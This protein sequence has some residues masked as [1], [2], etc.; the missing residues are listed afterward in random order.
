VGNTLLF[1]ALA[2]LALLIAL[3]KAIWARDSPRYARLYGPVTKILLLK[4][5]VSDIGLPGQLFPIF[6]AVMAPAMASATTLISAPA[7]PTDNLLGFCTLL[8]CGA[9]CV[10]LSYATTC[11]LSS[12]SV[13]VPLSDARISGK[14]CFTKPLTLLL[15]L[16]SSQS[17]W[18][19]M[20]P[21]KLS[22]VKPNAFSY[23]E[24]YG[25]LFEGYTTHAWFFVAELTSMLFLSILSGV[26]PTTAAGCSAVNWLV[27]TANVVLLLLAIALKPYNTVVDAHCFTYSCASAAVCGALILI[28]SEWALT[29][30]DVLAMMQIYVSLAVAVVNTLLKLAGIAGLSDAFRQ[31]R[32]EQTRSI[33]EKRALLALRSQRKAEATAERQ[34]LS[35]SQ[36]P[37][38][39]GG[40]ARLKVTERE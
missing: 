16:W 6:S 22:S 27:E 3:A 34:C 28:G 14:P 26:R 18:I 5:A 24:A 23:T 31:W 38:G 7:A 15:S 1:F 9:C 37:G 17:E 11:G 35:P 2:L 33:R 40:G 4:R 39:G 32:S 36:G 8:V 13:A 29:T 12:R 21:V 19:D 20:H 10:W 30:S 25:P